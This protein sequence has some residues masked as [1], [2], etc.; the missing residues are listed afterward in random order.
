LPLDVEYIIVGSGLS[1]LVLAERIANG[2]KR[3]V[4]IIEK[5]EH[6]GGNCYDYIDNRT[7]ILMNKYGA[8]IF[9]TNY[10]DV[11]TYIN[12]FSKWKRW[13]HTVIANVD[14]MYVPMP[15]NITTVNMLCNENLKNEDDIKSWLGKNQLKYNEIVNSEQMAKSRIGNVLYNKVI[16]DYTFKQWGMYP[17][18]LDKSVL[19]RIPVR[20]S[21]DPRYFNDKYQCLPVHGYSYLCRKIIENPLI[22]LML[23]VDFFDFRNIF[24]TSNKTIIY[25]GPIDLY[26]LS[27]ELPKLEYRS[28]DFHIR[29]MKN[30]NYYQPNS[31]VNYP[32]NNVPYTR[33]I[34]YKHFLNQKSKH[35]VVVSEVTKSI[36]EPY[37][38]IPNKRNIEL[39]EKY[40]LL[41]SNEKN[42]YFVGRLANYKYFNMDQTIKN[43]L[44]FYK[45]VLLKND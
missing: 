4:L 26:F 28:I 10:E 42:V 2:L 44:D 1:G 20:T 37:Y 25:T 38:P 40:K 5:R 32:S 35:T 19:E 14:N 43:A 22:K 16:R 15:V 7:D 3:K 36:G 17:D 45:N 12:R 13:E 31:V 6:I 8:H 21:Y 11:W 29:Y 23:N 18:Q 41:S 27:P 24:N 30:M 39:Y 33:I 34:E 9:H